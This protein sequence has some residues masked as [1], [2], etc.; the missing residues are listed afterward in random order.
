M[1]GRHT[2]LISLLLVI[3]LTVT[4]S[5]H[6]AE[7]TSS[8]ILSFNYHFS[9]PTIQLDSQGFHEITNSDMAISTQEGKPMLPSK[10]CYILLPYG[11]KLESITVQSSEPITL[12]EHFR[13]QATPKSIPLSTTTFQ[14]PIKAIQ[15]SPPEL[16]THVGTYSYRGYKIAV[17]LLHPYHYNCQTQQLTYYPEIDLCLST[18]LDQSFPSN[19]RGEQNDQNYV[20]TLIDNP[21]QLFSYPYQESTTK[22]QQYDLLIITNQTLKE[23][24]LPL[25]QIHNQQGLETVILTTDEIGSIW[26]EDI[27]NTIRTYY[28]DHGIDYVLLAGDHN[29]VPSA[30]LY[31]SGYDEDT[32]P[33]STRMPSDLYYACLDGPY[34]YDND[35]KWGEPTDGEDGGDV[36][37]LAE[38]FVGRAPAG[39]VQ[40]A[41]NFVQKTIAHLT[42][43]LSDEHE[44][45]VLFAGE[46]LGNY[47]VASYG[48]NYLDQFYDVCSE[49]G[50]TTQGI[51]TELYQIDELYERDTSWDSPDM[52]SALS[53]GYHL[54]NHLG[55]ANYY[56]NLKLYYTQVGQISNTK[57]TFIYSQGCMA[58]GFDDPEGY[59][60][61]AEYFTA[62]NSKGAFAVIMNA[63][64]GFF[65]AYRTD[66]DSQRYQR[67]F[68]DAIY[69]EGLTSLGEAN[70]DSK[71]DNLA[72]IQR[73]CMRWV[74]YQTNLFGDPSCKLYQ[75]NQPILELGNVSQEGFFSL[76]A[77]LSNTGGA[78]ATDISY[79]IE[80]TGPY[81][82]FKG[83]TEGTIDLLKSRE[84][85]TLQSNMI[86]GFGDFSITFTATQEETQTSLSEQR[87][88]LLF[89]ITE[90]V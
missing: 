89:Y 73:S 80:A 32:Y 1:H 41:E 44:Y 21:T 56:Y 83:K 25:Q 17:V 64:Y 62:K 76:T 39:T 14:Q 43:D 29:L 60:C 70:H 59:D 5:P 72:L 85:A 30:M 23:S 67:E 75:P 49:D 69:S 3:L 81:L 66:G 74:Y 40:E 68:W 33:L 77:T 18:V 13:F 16:Y 71:H 84:S 52:I 45:S 37:L 24:F 90:K 11:T 4:F 12:E 87:N 47:G 27:R 15:S 34:N 28:Q 22:Q 10:A 20:Q 48:G 65:W 88:I 51:P 79:S 58:G 26:P 35:T 86:I 63:R 57:P 8:E 31:V 38:V 78:D 6:M 36:D 82:L 55:H 19:Y 7:E 54:V 46:Y 2:T 50:Y 9:Q 53:Q 42:R 61:I